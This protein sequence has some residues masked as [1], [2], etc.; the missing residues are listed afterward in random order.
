VTA[1]GQLWRV[2]DL[3]GVAEQQNVDEYGIEVGG[4]AEDLA[5]SAAL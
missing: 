4:A 2:E 5:V 3:E 1:C